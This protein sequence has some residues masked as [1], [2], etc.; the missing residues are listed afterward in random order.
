M[1][2]CEAGE[3][4]G[5]PA[6]PSATRRGLRYVLTVFLGVRVGLFLLGAIAAKVVV[7]QDSVSVPGWAARPT[8]LGWHNVF[9]VW[10]RLDGLWFLRIAH[11]GYRVGDGSAVFFPGYPLAIRA[12]SLLIGGHEFAAAL[13][14]SN[15]AFAAGLCVLYFLTA[16]ELSVSVA[17]K[18]VLYM[19]IFPTSFFF[20]APYSESL[21]FLLTVTS[22]WAARRNRWALAG[23]L[24]ALAALTR[25]VGLLLA[26]ALAIEAVHQRM[27]R[28]GPLLPRLLG[29][30]S[31]GLGTLAYLG[32]WRARTGDFLAPLHEQSR[33]QRET[34]TPWHTLS[35]ATKQAFRWIG[36]TGKSFGGYWLIDWLIVVSVL[37][38]ATYGLWRLRPSYSVY[39]WTS[40]LVPLLYIFPD[41][42][43]MSMPRFV[44]PLFPALWMLAALAERRRLPHTAVVAASAA[45]LGLLTVLFVNWYYIF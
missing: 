24:G 5:A 12:V 2:T 22:F 30:A 42:A 36:A 1:R 35:E 32:Y 15:L 28:R 18:T 25:S 23:L 20:F 37:L 19:A 44:V 27:E 21:F 26:P 9:T 3:R 10:E 4:A 8:T 29:A 14:V 33:W 45:G 43:L 40:L 31:V 41:R 38:L 7:S 17:R 11:S 13:I 6:R 34:S 16:S 39:L